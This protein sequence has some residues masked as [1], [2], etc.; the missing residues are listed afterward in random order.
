MNITL[1]FKHNDN[2][3]QGTERV[4][5]NSANLKTLTQRV[6][7]VATISMKQVVSGSSP[8]RLE[9]S[10]HTIDSALRQPGRRHA[11]ALTKMVGCMRE[12][13]GPE[14]TCAV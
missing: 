12:R 9:L 2:F 4:L 8:F 5:R 10:D 13:R 7:E 6:C 3:E 14:D 1:S 11:D